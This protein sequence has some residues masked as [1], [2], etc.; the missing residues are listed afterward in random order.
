MMDISEDFN[1][2]DQ[3]DIVME[4]SPCKIMGGIIIRGIMC[5]RF[6]FVD[7]GY[8]HYWSDIRAY[9]GKVGHVSDGLIRTSLIVYFNARKEIKRID[10]FDIVK[11]EQSVYALDI[12]LT[13][14]D[15]DRY[16]KCYININVC[17]D[18]SYTINDSFNQ[19]SGI[20]KNTFTSTNDIKDC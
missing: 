2:T 1:I 10:K 5:T 6:N 16:R 15:L 7:Y 18:G 12:E 20:T 13:L 11:L 14:M 9:I 17:S 19:N 8:E 4:T 3:G